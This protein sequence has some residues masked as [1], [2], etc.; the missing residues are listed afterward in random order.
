LFGKKSE[1]SHQSVAWAVAGS[2]MALASGHSYR[3]APNWWVY[4]LWFGF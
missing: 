1:T 4:G 3:L 2:H